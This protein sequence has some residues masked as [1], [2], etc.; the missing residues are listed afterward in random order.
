[1]MAASDS[2]RLGLRLGFPWHK[3][4][5]AKPCFESVAAVAT[6]GNLT[7]AWPQHLCEEPVGHGAWFAIA[8]IAALAR[9]SACYEAAHIFCRCLPI[10]QL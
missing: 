6:N 7:G 3:L 4:E 5:W 2:E 9:G 1:M 10:V 8:D